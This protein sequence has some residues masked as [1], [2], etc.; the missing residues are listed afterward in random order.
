MF[1][2][3]ELYRMKTMR[4]I[5]C[6]MCLPLISSANAAGNDSSGVPDIP[7]LVGPYV[8]QDPPGDTPVLFAP[9]VISTG[10]EHSAAMFTPEGNEIWFGRMFPAKI[11]YMK[12]FDGKWT[13]PQIAPFCDTCNYLYPVLTHDGNRIFF[14]SDRPFKP[15]GGRLPRG[16]VD[17][18]VL[19]R[20]PHGWSEPRHLN[21]H[22]NLG[23]RSSCGSIAANGDL[24]FSGQAGGESV[25]IFCSSFIDDDYAIPENLTAIDSPS[26]D[27]CPFIARDGSYLIFSSFRGGL[28]RSDLFISFRKPDG[29]WS[30]PQNLGPTINS[31]Y[32]DEYPYVS[33]DGKYLFF[34]SNRPSSINR[35]PIE[36]GPGNIYWVDAKIFKILNRQRPP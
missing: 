14:S 32:K 11:Y 25:D 20:N 30:E 17:I 10:R 23:R 22:I 7:A 1:R 9:G 15:N 6:M 28:G 29:S 34:N 13:E 2:K 21:D 5:I 36:D 26:P 33:P 31:A 3:D 24:Y 16:E 4:F 12:Q 18:W 35:K 27:H 8:G 19:E